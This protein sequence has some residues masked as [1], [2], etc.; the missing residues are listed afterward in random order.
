MALKT[1]FIGTETTSGAPITPD[2]LDVKIRQNLEDLAAQIDAISLRLSTIGT[3]TIAPVQIDSI[4]QAELEAQIV[5]DV[6]SWALVSNTDE[7]P[8]DKLPDADPDTKGIIE[9]ADQ[10]DADAGSNTLNAMTPAL[11]KR[12]IDAAA[13]TGATIK[14]KLEALQGSARL[15]ASAIQNL[16]SGGAGTPGPAGPAGPAG[17]QGPA[18]PKGD[19]GDAGPAGPAGPAG[20]PDTA[21]QIVTKL[22]T[23]AGTARLSADAIKNLPQGSKWAEGVVAFDTVPSDVSDFPL[24]TV[25][26]VNQPGGWYEVDH[27]GTQHQHTL[28]FT[29]ATASGVRGAS[30]VSGG[31]GFESAARGTLNTQEGTALTQATSPVGL[32]AVE[33]WQSNP[34]TATMGQLKIY[35]KASLNPPSELF[36]KAYNGVP[37]SST[38]IAPPPLVGNNLARLGTVTLGG[39]QYVSYGAAQEVSSAVGGGTFGTNFLGT[40]FQFFLNNGETQPFDIF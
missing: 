10:S 24:N 15:D 39:V 9:V 36:Y 30:V 34:I 37:S 28:R 19:D 5:S 17:P 13:E 20:S 31:S 35:I 16:P 8:E 26:R 32:I 6:A 4:T 7:V 11:V 1:P 3:Q 40:Y 29:P 14:T 2:L 22:Q 12:R 38:F 33:P 23:L 18:G 27:D 25:V 21:A